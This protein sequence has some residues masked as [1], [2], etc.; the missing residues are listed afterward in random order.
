VFSLPNSSRQIETSQRFLANILGQGILCN[1]NL[2]RRL[3][4]MTAELAV[5]VH[6]VGICLMSHVSIVIIGFI[7][8]NKAHVVSE[9]NPLLTKFQKVLRRECER[10]C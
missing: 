9:A 6:Y 1:S 10:R 3:L 5:S 2:S 8:W 4:Q 7:G